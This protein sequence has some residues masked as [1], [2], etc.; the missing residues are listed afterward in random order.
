MLK[1]KLQY[2]GH[3]M[4]RTDSMDHWKR[5]WCWERLKVGGEGDDRGWDG[6]MASP[7]Q[8][9][10]VWVNSGSLLRVYSIYREAWSA[11]VHGVAKSQTWLSNWTKLNWIEIREKKNQMAS[12]GWGGEKR[13]NHMNFAVHYKEVATGVILLLLLCSYLVSLSWKWFHLSTDYLI[14]P[15]IQLSKA[16]IFPILRMWRVR[17]WFA[18][19]KEAST[20]SLKHFTLKKKQKLKWQQ[21]PKETTRTLGN[22]M[23]SLE[24]DD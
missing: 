4:L 15:H 10:W 7:T 3:Q 21:H 24:S 5:P 9:T 14:F 16:E 20:P 13:W 17:Q 11:A 12:A 23:V 2:F 22:K 6:W 18:S 1:L 8:W 19:M